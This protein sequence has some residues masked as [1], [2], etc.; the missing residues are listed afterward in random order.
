MQV[1][2]FSKGFDRASFE[3]GVAELDAYL[4]RQLSQ[5]VRKNT[6]AA[7]IL[8]EAE[9]SAILGYYTLSAFSIELSAVPEDLRNKLPR[10]PQV[11]ATM[12]GRLAVDESTQGQGFGELL[13]MDALRR[14]WENRAII[15]SWALVVDALGESAEHFYQHF[16]FRQIE[17]EDGRL[18]LSMNEISKLFVQA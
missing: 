5:E 10:Y 3:C 17:G 13:L 7:F 4:K 1:S 16:G 14:S 8:H 15:G 6:A 11:P 18:F 12:L 9:S 2:P